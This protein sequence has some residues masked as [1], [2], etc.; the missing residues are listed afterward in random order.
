VFAQKPSNYHIE[1]IVSV[2][3]AKTNKQINKKKNKPK[4]NEKNK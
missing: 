3:I 1:C 4:A 2:L